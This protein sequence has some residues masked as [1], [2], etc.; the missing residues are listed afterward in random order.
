MCLF[1]QVVILN[2]HVIRFVKI[3]FG[4]HYQHHLTCAVSNFWLEYWFKY[5]VL[6]FVFI[7]RIRLK[8]AVGICNIK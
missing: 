8:T 2:L 5:V 7:A 4:G 6:N 3:L 1:W